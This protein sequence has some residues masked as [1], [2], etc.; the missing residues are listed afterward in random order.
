MS[1]FQH[2]AEQEQIGAFKGAGTVTEAAV[3]AEIDRKWNG[4]KKAAIGYVG[5]TS[6]GLKL[7]R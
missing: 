5:S 4:R 7:D 6:G 1:N 2:P 3:L